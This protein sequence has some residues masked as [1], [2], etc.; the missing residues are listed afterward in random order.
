MKK[1]IN[2]E[3]NEVIEVELSKEDITQ[4]NKNITEA[5]KIIKKEEAEAETKAIA[6]AAI[7]DRI[8]LSADELKTI[9]G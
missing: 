9:L 3:T 1:I 5:N 7:L 2:C 6:K 8:G 4:R